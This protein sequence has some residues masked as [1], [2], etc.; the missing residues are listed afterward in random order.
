[1]SLPPGVYMPDFK[2]MFSESNSEVP[3][4]MLILSIFNGLKLGFLLHILI[5][6]PASINFL[7]Y[8]SGQLGSPSPQAHPIIRQYALLLMTSVVIAIIYMLRPLDST[9][10]QVAGA[11]GIYHVGPSLRSIARLQTRFQQG[12]SLIYSEASL[13]L[14]VHT[15]TGAAL[16]HCCLCLC[17]PSAFS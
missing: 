9:S 6:V 1:M 5:E 2:Y 12:H 7:V 10:G 8:P 3:I 16:A 4:D 13:Y 15:V 14:F 11:L 17:F